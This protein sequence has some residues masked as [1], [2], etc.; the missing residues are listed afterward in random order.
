MPQ[1]VSTRHDGRVGVDDGVAEGRG[2][3]F[4]DDTAFA[5][6][7]FEDLHLFPAALTPQRHRL[8]EVMYISHG[9]GLCV[10]DFESFPI[11]PPALCF[12]APGQVHF[13]RPDTTLQGW[14]AVFSEDFLLPE[15]RNVDPRLI[16]ELIDELCE[17]HV[18]HLPPEQDASAYRLFQDI[19]EEHRDRQP[20]AA[21]AVRALLTFLL[22]QA[23]RLR[24][25]DPDATAVSESPLLHR[26]RDLLAHEQPPLR[27][28]AEAARRLGVSESHLSDVTRRAT[29]SS[30]G[31]HLRRAVTLEAKRLLTMT[32]LTGEQ[33][34]HRLG[35][36]DPAYFSRFFRR[37]A[38]VSPSQFRRQTREKY[39][40]SDG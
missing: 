33:V 4:G 22:V 24:L 3:V 35:F 1:L 39:H 7:T 9:T 32:D 23:Y 13:W 25:A 37:Q 29:G 34:G 14:G 18:V 5:V 21:T 6:G 30:P 19:E 31:V 40:L 11:E 2:P 38:G 20:H 17:V 16:V 12:T 10:V 8:F 27:S 28:V 36:E 15:L 26:F